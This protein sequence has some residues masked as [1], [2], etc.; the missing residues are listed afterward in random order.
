[1]IVYTRHCMCRTKEKQRLHALKEKYG[2]VEVRIV[3]RSKQW[4][5]EA[6]S[7]NALLPFAV[8]DGLVYDFYSGELV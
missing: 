6:D 3:T 1:M 7:F 5:L 4:R 2:Q 8:L